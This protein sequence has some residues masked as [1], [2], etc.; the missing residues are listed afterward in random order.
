[1]ANISRVSAFFS[2][3]LIKLRIQNCYLHYLNCLVHDSSD[4]L[5]I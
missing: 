5:N 3:G 2:I 4:N 1:M